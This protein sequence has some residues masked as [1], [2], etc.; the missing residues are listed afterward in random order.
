MSVFG[1]D[2]WQLGHIHALRPAHP[3]AAPQCVGPDPLT[4]I[5]TS[6]V[7]NITTNAGDPRMDGAVLPKPYRYEVVLQR[8]QTAIH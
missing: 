1:F 6:G 3:R 5:L 4:V 8:I 7:A 2:H